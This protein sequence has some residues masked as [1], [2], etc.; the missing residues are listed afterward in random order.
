MLRFFKEVKSRVADKKGKSSS[1]T[2]FSPSIYQQLMKEKG[3][4]DYIARTL[5]HES[6]TFGLRFLLHNRDSCLYFAPMGTDILACGKE[7][8]V[9][10]THWESS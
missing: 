1:Q 10:I 5:S 3:V 8:R 2:V 6:Q 7:G 4:D 9:K